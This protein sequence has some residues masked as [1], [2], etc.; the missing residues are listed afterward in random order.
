MVELLVLEK[1]KSVKW[2]LT[3]KLLRSKFSLEKS[4]TLVQMYTLKSIVLALVLFSTSLKVVTRHESF[5][6]PSVQNLFEV[7]FIFL[8]H[9]A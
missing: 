3:W 4:F 6:M 5:F 8:K 1:L 2:S 7:S 9:G